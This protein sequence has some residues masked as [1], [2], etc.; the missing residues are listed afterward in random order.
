MKSIIL[1]IASASSIGAAF[2]ADLKNTCDAVLAGGIRDNFHVYSSRQQ[3]ELYQ[4]R[5]CDAKFSSHADFESGSSSLGI[6]I[7]LAEMSFGLSGTTESKRQSFSES[8]RKY[9]ESTYSTFQYKEKFEQSSATVNQTLVQS[10]GSC[11]RDFMNAYILGNQRGIF[12]SASPKSD[13]TGFVVKVNRRNGVP[14]GPVI[15]NALFPSD[16]QCNRG[17][18]TFGPGAA[19]PLNEFQFECNK[20]ASQSINFSIDT[21][22]GASNEVTIPSEIP[23]YNELRDR[24]YEQSSSISALESRLVERITNLSAG[25]NCTKTAPMMKS[26]NAWQTLSCP[27]GQ[28]VRS[29]GFQHANKQD[30]TYQEQVQIEC[31]P[32][33]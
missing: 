15:V 22:D 10:W 28:Y 26:S 11:Q 12:V 16:L 17:G 32:L 3:F 4:K 29:V 27:A 23:R 18:Q 7:P 8:Y 24:L 14:T 25:K 6:D 1:C 9:C 20:S 13:L 30:Y 19:V 31:C 2:A 21:G 5:L 33:Q